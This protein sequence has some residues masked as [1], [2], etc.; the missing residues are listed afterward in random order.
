M[1][2][3]LEELWAPVVAITAAHGDR[4]NGLI[5]STAVSASLLPEAPRVVV[6]LSKANLTHDLVLASG[7]FAL[8][9]LRADSLELV[10]A[11][12]LRSGRDGEKM[13]GIETRPGLTGSPILADALA[14]LEA[15]VASTLDGDDVTILLADVVGGGR[16]AEGE[17][18]TIETVRER[19]PVEWLAEWDARREQEIAEGRRRRAAPP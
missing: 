16:L 15:R 9:F 4:R 8:H 12:G 11:L 5:A 7:S 2:E 14:Y 10:R 17:R 6:Q 19:M 3:L 13:A 18:L 1:T